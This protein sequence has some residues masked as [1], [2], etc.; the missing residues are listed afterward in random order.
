MSNEPLLNNL[1]LRQDTWR[2]RNRSLRRH[3]IAT[4]NE[5]LDRL[6]L[7]GWPVSALTEL[8][9]QQDGIGELSLLLPTV[10]HYASENKL[11]VWLDPP[12]QPYAPSL[13]NEGVPLDKLL[14][15][16][17]KNSKEWLWAA[18]QSI[19]GKALLFAW[20]NRAQPRYSALRKLQLAATESLAPVFLFSPP[21]TLKAHSPALLRLELESLEPN[22][23]SVTLHKLRGKMPGAKT[24]ITLG[25]QTTGRILLDKLPVNIQYPKMPQTDF[26]L[27]QK[28]DVQHLNT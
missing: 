15:V 21:N 20:A 27:V 5:N 19:R 22:I 12:Y 28:D 3:V 13:V 2:G 6:L 8:V 7:G 26:P 10:K 23:L 25:E 1:L 4:G 14:I 9:T 11:C 16:R 17:S 18:E 24:Q